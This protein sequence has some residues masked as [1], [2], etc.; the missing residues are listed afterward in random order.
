MLD[1][2][3]NNDVVLSTVL[4]HTT[5]KLQPLERIVM[6]RLKGYYNQEAVSFINGHKYKTM[7]VYNIAELLGKAYPK[8]FPS[9]NII[10]RI[11][12]IGVYPTNRDVFKN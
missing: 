3:K 9:E 2:A 7:S 10:S 6:R 12:T 1:L 8:F 4:P 5:H 11:R